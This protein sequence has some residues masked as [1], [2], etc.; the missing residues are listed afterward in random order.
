MRQSRLPRG[1]VNIF[2]TIRAKR[3]EAEASGIALLDLSIGEPKRP[4]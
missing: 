4:A 2:Q 3:A 1:G